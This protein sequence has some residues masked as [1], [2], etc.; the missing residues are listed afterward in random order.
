[1]DKVMKIIVAVGYVLAIVL[2]MFLIM[3]ALWAI[4]GW[5]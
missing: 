1:M 2:S 4:G 3:I 5:F